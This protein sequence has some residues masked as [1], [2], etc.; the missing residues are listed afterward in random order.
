MIDD[1]NREA[2]YSEIERL[3]KEYKQALAKTNRLNYGK[4]RVL[5]KAARFASGEYIVFPDADMGL[6]P[7]QIQTFF[8]IMRLDEADIV[9]GVYSV[10]FNPE[11]FWRRIINIRDSND[12]KYFTRAGIK[13]LGHLLDFRAKG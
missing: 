11:L 4:G 2:T 5:K 9:Q 10:A 7:G 12:V 8:N 13:V 1:G 6:Y 3:R